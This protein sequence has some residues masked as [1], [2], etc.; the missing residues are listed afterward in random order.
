LS[1]NAR[2][3]SRFCYLGRVASATQLIEDAIDE[4]CRFGRLGWDGRLLA[5]AERLKNRLDFPVDRKAAGLRLR[6][7]ECVI[8]ENVELTGRA[9]RDFGSFTKPPFE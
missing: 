3:G 8:D 1:G 2:W 4:P 6:E 9:R 5:I 7:D